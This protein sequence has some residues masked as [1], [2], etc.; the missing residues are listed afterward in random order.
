MLARENGGARDGSGGR[1]ESVRRSVGHRPDLDGTGA[2]SSNLAAFG[3]VK[4][5]S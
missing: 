3:Y 5:C 2:E 4:V 1:I